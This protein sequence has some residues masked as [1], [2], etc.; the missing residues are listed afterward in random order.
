MTMEKAFDF[1]VPQVNV[2]VYK[3]RY[4]ST[5]LHSA[6]RPSGSHVSDIVVE[7][8]AANN[9]RKWTLWIFN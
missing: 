8:E 2:F 9:E 3:V 6:V 4:G 1:R 7:V 5:A